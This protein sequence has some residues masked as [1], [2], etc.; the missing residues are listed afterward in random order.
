VV[1]L[2]NKNKK[3]FPSMIYSLSLAISIFVV[4][5]VTIMSTV[6]GIATRR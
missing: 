4:F 6:V 5:V 2:E 3:H 1:V